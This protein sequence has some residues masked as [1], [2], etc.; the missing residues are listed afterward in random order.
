MLYKILVNYLSKILCNLFFIFEHSTISSL[1]IYPLISILLLKDKLC[2]I[3]LLLSSQ[4]YYN[5]L[6]LKLVYHSNKSI[7]HILIFFN[8]I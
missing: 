3:K 2:L 7:F 5:N 8:N 1:K 6:R 4:L